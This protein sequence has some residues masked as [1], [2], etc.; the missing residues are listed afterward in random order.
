MPAMKTKRF[1]TYRYTCT[2]PHSKTEKMGNSLSNELNTGRNS[3]ASQPFLPE[4]ELHEDDFLSVVPESQLSS[5]P[6][7][8]MRAKGSSFFFS[9]SP[10]RD[11]YSTD[12]ITQEANVGP[13]W[14]FSFTPDGRQLAAGAEFD[15][16]VVY[17][18][19]TYQASFFIDREGNTRSVAYSPDGKY[20]AI[21]GDDQKLAI[22]ETKDYNMYHEVTVAGSIRSL[23]YSP[24]GKHIAFA[25]K[26]GKVALYDTEMREIVEKHERRP[27]AWAL[28]YSPDGQYISVGGHDRKITVHRSDNLKVV[29]EFPR[30]G[31]I[32]SLAYSPDGRFV[33]VGCNDHTIEIYDALTYAIIHSHKRSGPVACV[34]YTVDGKTILAGGW[35]KK[36]ALYDASTFEVLR[37]YR[38][39]GT[40]WAV[41]GCPTGKSF[42]A[43]G[44]D[45][46]LA[47]YTNATTSTASHD[48]KMKDNA[49]AVSYS[50]NGKILASGGHDNILTICDTSTMKVLAE[51]ERE[52]TIRAIKFSPCSQKLA[53]AGEDKKVTIYDIGEFIWGEGNVSVTKEL[54]LKGQSFALDFSPNGTQLAIGGSENKVIF[55][56]SNDLTVVNEIQREGWVRT[57]TYSPDGQFIAAG[58]DDKTVTVYD[59]ETSAKVHE[60]ERSGWVFA[61]AFSPDGT[62]L[63]AG[64]NDKKLIIYELKTFQVKYENND[65]EIAALAFSRNGKYLA[66]GGSGKE[67][68]VLDVDDEFQEFI[69]PILLPH[70]ISA[71]AFHPSDIDLS[72]NY[73]TVAV[74][75]GRYVHSMKLHEYASTPTEV[76]LRNS[77]DNE[78]LL[79]IDK[80]KISIH[81]QVQL[82][83]AANALDADSESSDH[84]RNQLIAGIIDKNPSYGLLAME[85][86]VNDRSNEILKRLEQHN[87]L[88][89]LNAVARCGAFRSRIMESD[90]NEIHY[91]VLQLARKQ[92]KSSVVNFLNAGENGSLPGFVN[93]RDTYLLKETSK[94]SFLPSW[95]LPTFS[96]LTQQSLSTP[97]LTTANVSGHK[98]KNQMPLSESMGPRIFHSANVSEAWGDL[99]KDKRK[100]IPVKIIRGLIPGLGS[101]ESLKA[102]TKM[103]NIEPFETH[104]LRA[105]ID[106]HWSNWARTR[107]IFEAL[108]YIGWVACYSCF[109]FIDCSARDTA[110]APSW[111]PSGSPS[112]VPS[113]S[114]SSEP[115][116]MSSVLFPSTAPS[117]VLSGSPSTDT[118]TIDVI[119]YLLL[120]VIFVYVS[121][122]IR[123]EYSQFLNNKIAYFWDW[124]NAFQW[125]TT[126]LICI[127][128]IIRL[129]VCKETANANALKEADAVVS[130]LALLFGWYGLIF[131][132]RGI[133]GCAWIVMALFHIARS[134]VYFV[135]VLLTT[136]IGFSFFFYSLSKHSSTSPSLATSCGDTG[137][138]YSN[139]GCSFL[140]VFDAGING[141]LDIDEALELHA[142]RIALFMMIILA[143]TVTLIS[144]NALIAFM[145]AAFQDVLTTKL[146]VLKQQKAS[147]ILDFYSIMNK[148]ERENIE[149]KYKWTTLIV[150]IERLDSYAKQ[151]T[152]NDALKSE[153]DH[154][155]TDVEGMKDDVKEIL[156]FM[157]ELIPPGVA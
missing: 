110:T 4:D 157:K 137:G 12:L 72:H 128:V 105:A 68:F 63:A 124:W 104:A 130:G 123:R 99:K 35:D 41:A 7:T 93:V 151:V 48:L 44:D 116:D 9:N 56:N 10:V 88:V 61:L 34:T 142:P 14:A 147:I 98:Q 90:L 52:G 79:N 126:L 16:V 153:V 33:A 117:C 111:V 83:C 146:A 92:F 5:G 21:G 100:Q 135:V 74:A 144:L 23:A 57:I 51:V 107:F 148:K 15:Q 67:L 87:Q 64:G 131:F 65:H 26:M 62:H 102:F 140:S 94:K 125:T 82:I 55:L 69:S 78:I 127:S 119:R 25:G 22:Y 20:L 112:W 1:P 114:P 84:N 155:R 133:E 118:G 77:N 66:G 89:E 40:I 113:G 29:K 76:L 106:C 96:Q 71:L 156:A 138:G 2:T 8:L 46:V 42:I 103:D 101:F 70:L 152:Q 43:S 129:Q 150:P 31:A 81:A 28:A 59:T 120:A 115:F 86:L 75:D 145:G 19:A 85:N 141:S 37:E 73:A 18:T 97:M 95:T 53:V 91:V 49:R 32:Q 132:F 6:D 13:I 27:T 24:D 45:G 122:F 60:H 17:N 134:M 136:L 11:L 50:P 39:D 139:F 143:L 30:G 38:R 149:S 47:I 36:V 154:L 3:I 58:G 121:F 80:H 109:T 54:S 108:R